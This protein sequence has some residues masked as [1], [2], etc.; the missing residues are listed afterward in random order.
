MA[1]L[2]RMIRQAMQFCSREPPLSGFLRYQLNQSPFDVS[3]APRQAIAAKPASRKHCAAHANAAPIASGTQITIRCR[4][5][6]DD[7]SHLTLER[8]IDTASSL[9]FAIPSFSAA[10]SNLSASSTAASRSGRYGPRMHIVR[11]FPELPNAVP[12]V[13][14]SSAW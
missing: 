13:N 12:I 3:S 4:S 1:I 10:F 6:S 5:R 14:I 8:F 11:A 7:S 2:K 9:T